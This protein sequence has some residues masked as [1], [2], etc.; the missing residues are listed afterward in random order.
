MGQ[1][2]SDGRD[3]FKDT[4]PSKISSITSQDPYHDNDS[5]SELYVPLDSRDP[6]LFHPVSDYSANDICYD[7]NQQTPPCPSFGSALVNGEVVLRTLYA[8]MDENSAS[9]PK[10]SFYSL[11]LA[12]W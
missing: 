11:A 5:E 7:R 8:V 2:G 10:G 6:I 3:Y 9:R 1:Q 12:H 4:L